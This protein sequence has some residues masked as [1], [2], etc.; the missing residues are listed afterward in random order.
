M[1]PSSIVDLSHPLQDPMTCYPGD[2]GFK[3]KSACNFS[4]SNPSCQMVIVTHE[5]ALSTHTGTHVD[6]PFHFF[7]DGAKLSEIPVDRFVGRAV[8][9]DV[10]PAARARARIDW[11]DVDTAC[12]KASLEQIGPR[13]EGKVD[14][15]LLWTGWDAHWDTPTYYAHPYF[16]REVSESLRN[17]GAQLVGM[18]TLGPDETPGDEAG[19]VNS[20]SFAAHEVLL[21]GG[22][23]ICENLRRIGSLV[24][25]EEVWISMVPLSV[26]GSDGSPVRAYGWRQ[27]R[28]QSN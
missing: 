26:R 12:N 21:G 6:A 16:S 15:V 20:E 11:A 10:R 14:I 2:A 5:L 8:V 1:L 4:I 19:E 25:D 22:R 23:I 3:M 7:P 27:T 18:D 28:V 24:G 17:M 9:L 13:S